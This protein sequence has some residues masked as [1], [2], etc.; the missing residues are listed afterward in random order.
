MAINFIVGIL[1]VKR[2]LFIIALIVPFIFSGGAGYNE[3]SSVQSS[4]NMQSRNHSNPIVPPETK[5]LPT[6]PV[7]PLTPSVAPTPET[8]PTPP[9]TTSDESVEP[10]ATPTP[11][12]SPTDNLNNYVPPSPASNGKIQYTN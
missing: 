8:S 4:H 5:P 11:D 10:P 2:L 7:I 6:D 3:V 9:G 1:F 12:T